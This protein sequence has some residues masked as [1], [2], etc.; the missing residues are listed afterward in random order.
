MASSFLKC[1]L[2]LGSWT[3][4]GFNPMTYEISCS[5]KRASD[6]WSQCYGDSDIV[7]VTWAY[8]HWMEGTDTTESAQSKMA[9][10][11]W[12]ACFSAE[13]QRGCSWV[14]LGQNSVDVNWNYGLQ[15]MLLAEIPLGVLRLWLTVSK[16]ENN[17]FPCRTAGTFNRAVSQAKSP[18][19]GR[20]I[21]Q[22]TQQE[23][24]KE[25]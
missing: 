1:L 10:L 23:G 8:W 21:H 17:H 7:P 22:E 18:V 9:L 24:W 3:R 5:S 15:E 14:A 13:C 19:L 6:V 11:M 20:L 25:Q 4:P 16:A 12:A 2:A